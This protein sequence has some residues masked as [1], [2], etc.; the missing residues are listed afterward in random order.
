[1]KSFNIEKENLDLV[2]V[3][4]NNIVGGAKFNDETKASEYKARKEQKGLLI[5]PRWKYNLHWKK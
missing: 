2:D 3:K 5:M 4:D 1:M